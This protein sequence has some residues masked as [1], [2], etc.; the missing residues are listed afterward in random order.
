MIL[1]RDRVGHL[2]DIGGG[3]PIQKLTKYWLFVELIFG[4]GNSV[5]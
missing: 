5:A 2:I 1:M 4:I 3:Y